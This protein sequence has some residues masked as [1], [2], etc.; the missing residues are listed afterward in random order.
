MA[1][2]P[3][4]A[5]GTFGFNPGDTAVVFEAFDRIGVRPP[6][7]DRHM[8]FSA[9]DSLNY[10]FIEWE[11]NGVQLWKVVSG[12]IDLVPGQASYD[13]PASLVTLTE[14]WYSQPN[15]LGAGIPSDRILTPM[16]RT[17][18]AMLPNKLQEGTPTQYWY[19]MLATPVLTLWQVPSSGAGA[20]TY[21][22]NWYGLQQMDDATLGSGETPNVVRRALGALT[23]GMAFKLAEKFAP[24]RMAEKKALYDQAWTNMA[25]RDQELGPTVIQP[26][27]GVYGRIY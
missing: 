21:V 19:Q 9:R 5:S 3:G 17:Q 1:V 12:T 20:P 6:Q 25:T 27:A 16:T 22:V 2:T 4:T 7:V 23:A 18:Y 8:M 15:G 11:N 10:L 13:M 26:T 24:P 14:A